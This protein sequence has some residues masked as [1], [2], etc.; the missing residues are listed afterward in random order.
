MPQAGI[1]PL[2]LT[3]D[4]EH[5]EYPIVDTS[6]SKDTDPL[7]KIRRTKADSLYHWYKSFTGAQKAPYSGFANEGS[8]NWKQK[9]SRFVRGNF[10]L[11]DL[12][13]GWNPYAYHQAALWILQEAP[14]CVI[15]TGPPMSTHLIGQRL[16]RRFPDV[17]WIADFR[18]PWTDIYYYERMYPTA[19]AKTIDLRMELSVLRDADEVI[20]VSPFVTGLLQSKLPKEQQFKF[21]CI[22]NGFDPDDYPLQESLPPKEFTICYTG[23]MADNYPM[24]GFISAI[25]ALQAKYSIRL[26][27]VGK[28]APAIRKHLISHIRY[29]DFIGFVPHRQ[30]VQYLQ[31]SS[32]LLLVLPLDPGARDI[33]PGKVFEYIGSGTPTL[34]LGDPD[35]DAGQILNECGAGRAIESAETTLIQHFIEQEIL[36]PKQPRYPATANHPY[37]RQ[38]LL[39]RLVNEVILPH[40]RTSHEDC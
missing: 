22:T 23:T 15:T 18:D 37:S 7:L 13:K 27:M 20:G 24:D 5:A 26:V 36:K 28:I 4:L 33:I 3:V 30:S 38:S 1:E 19:L 34:C 21:H 25:E 12:R 32:L 6:L 40:S 17:K 11:P 10:F 29:I 35:S 9:I 2:V 16:K 14:D 39:Q 8:P 31:E